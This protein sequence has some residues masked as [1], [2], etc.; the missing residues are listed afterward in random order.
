MWPPVFHSLQLVAQAWQPTQVSR[1]MTRPSFFAGRG[2]QAWSSGRLAAARG[3][4]RRN[5]SIV[6]PAPRDAGRRAA[7]PRSAA[8]STPPRS[9]AALAR[10]ARAGRTMPPGRS[11]DRSWSSAGRRPAGQQLGDHVVEQEAA[12]GLRRVVVEAP[13]A[14]RLP[15]AFQVHTVSGLTP[16]ISSH[17]RL[18]PAVRLS[19]HTQSS[20]ARPSSR[21]WRDARRAGCGR[22]ICR[23]QAF[24]E[25]QEWYM[26]IGRWVMRVQRERV[27]VDGR[28]L[29]R[30][31]P[32]RQ[33]I[34]IGLDARAHA[35]RA[36]APRRGPARRGGIF[37]S[38]SQ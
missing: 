25:P 10:C 32:D 37:C 34:E 19:I 4:R 7:A 21:G 5:A 13:G 38:G 35:G 14:A 31:V 29:E 15:M 24:C 26:C 28:L 1:S 27:A 2:R 22:W 20:S 36:A 17:L 3:T 33:R 30:R 23:S 18:D 6:G 8:R 11:P 16:S 12:A 9:V